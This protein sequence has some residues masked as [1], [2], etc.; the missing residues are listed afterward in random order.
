MTKIKVAICRNKPI[1][2][3]PVPITRH[4]IASY[5]ICRDIQSD[6]EIPEEVMEKVLEK[7]YIVLDRDSA[8]GILNLRVGDNEYIKIYIE[9]T[10]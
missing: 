7:G 1:E 2:H 8:L 4:I 9:D 10:P 5:T 3:L 6:I